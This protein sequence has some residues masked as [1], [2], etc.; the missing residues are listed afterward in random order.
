MNLTRQNL[1]GTISPAFGNLTYLWNLYLGGNN[2]MGSIPESLATLPQLKA[3][4]VS[5]NNLS[6]NIPKFSSKVKFIATGNI[7]L[8]L[9]QPNG[10]SPSAISGDRSSSTASETSLS[11]RWIAGTLIIAMPKLS[12]ATL[13]PK[14]K[15]SSKLFNRK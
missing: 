12:N 6:G 7:F 2:L 8:G 10:T 4:D 9:S 1:T 3:L 15:N 13:T 5:N 11:P 14:N